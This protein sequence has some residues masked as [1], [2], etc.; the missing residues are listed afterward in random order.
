MPFLDS[1]RGRCKAPAGESSQERGVFIRS[2][3]EQV[4]SVGNWGSVPRGLSSRQCTGSSEFAP[5]PSKFPRSFERWT[6]HTPNSGIASTCHQDASVIL[7]NRTSQ[8]APLGRGPSS[9]TL[10][11]PGLILSLASLK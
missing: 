4:A 11:D 7:R 9:G 3:S 6:Y 8:R 1:L 2:K 10:R 5:C